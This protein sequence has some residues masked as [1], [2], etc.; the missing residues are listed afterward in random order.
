MIFTDYS[1]KRALLK[2][3]SPKVSLRRI[4]GI[5]TFFTSITLLCGCNSSPAGDP[6]LPVV[7][8]TR[9]PCPSAPSPV[10]FTDVTK[11]AGLHFSHNT[12]GF[13]LRLYPETVGSGAVFFDYDGDGWQDIFFVN[14]RDWTATEIA[15]YEKRHGA[16]PSQK[17]GSNLR[18]FRENAITLR[19]LYHNNGDGTFR[20][21]TKNSGLDIEILGL[22]VTAGDY[23]N[24][25][26][27][28]LYITGYG[29]NYLLHNEGDG[30]FIEV[31]ERAGV[32]D[33]GFGTSAAWVDYDRDGLLDLFVCRYIDWNPGN[34]IWAFGSR[35]EENG[36]YLKGFAGPVYYGG[37]PSQLYRNLGK[38]RFANVTRQTGIYAPTKNLRPHDAPLA[39]LTPIPPSE[40]RP[41]NSKDLQRDLVPLSKHQGKSLGVAIGDFNYDLWPDIFVANDTVRDYLFENQ[42]DGTFRE[43]A[44]SAGV[45]YDRT[46]KARAG[47]GVDTG[48]ID[49]TGHEASWSEISLTNLPDYIKISAKI[50]PRKLLFMLVLFARTRRF[51]T[52]GCLFADVD[53]DG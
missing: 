43:I 2:S 15:Q 50:Y 20:D 48:D 46:G 36:T 4:Y 33:S 8:P 38:G 16:C 10:S 30:K 40:F 22:G 1:Q 11:I 14:G 3:C 21:T 23:D 53:N 25:G 28:D 37:Q 52:F 9:M 45:A 18:L 6:S 35:E 19:A 17:T 12:G 26:R 41:K 44:E 29:R 5:G 7:L 39:A 34:D 32:R 47:M 49:H 31:A 24:D 13:G 27:I 51:L 42:K